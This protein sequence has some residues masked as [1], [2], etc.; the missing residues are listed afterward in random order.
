MYLKVPYMT[1]AI[2]LNLSDL[3][4]REMNFSSSISF[5]SAIVILVVAVIFFIYR[6]RFRPHLMIGG[7]SRASVFSRFFYEPEMAMPYYSKMTRTPEQ[8]NR[9]AF[10]YVKPGKLKLIMGRP[11]RLYRSNDGSWIYPWNFNQYVYP[12]CLRQAALICKEPV[13][14]LIK[15]E[16]GKLGGLGVVTPKDVIHTSQCFDREFQK[17]S[18]EQL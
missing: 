1:Y 7:D 14:T 18:A 16:M 10:T 4:T 6:K 3:Y 15:T 11:Y 13:V 2:F 17:C 12:D 9:L 5:V 8:D